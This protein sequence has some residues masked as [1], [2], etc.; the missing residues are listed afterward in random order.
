LIVKVRAQQAVAKGV[1]KSP[2]FIQINKIEND[3]Q[4]YYLSAYLVHTITANHNSKPDWI[5]W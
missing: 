2:L 5:K 4:F 3:G 1:L